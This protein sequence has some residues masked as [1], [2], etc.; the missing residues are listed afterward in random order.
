MIYCDYRCTGLS[1]RF[2]IP[3]PAA[4]LDGTFHIWQV[5]QELG[6]ENVNIKGSQM[7][8]IIE[9][10]KKE[11]DIEHEERLTANILKSKKSESDSSDVP[12][13]SV[14][15]TSSKSTDTQV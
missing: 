13:D 9:L 5:L 15:D 1:H 12:V 10:L 3:L 14:T 8:G 6:T 2:G 11:A 4:K 7:T